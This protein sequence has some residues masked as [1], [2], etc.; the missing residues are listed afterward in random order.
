[1]A[2]NLAPL[3]R[4]SDGRWRSFER[5]FPPAGLDDEEI[6]HLLRYALLERFLGGA[7]VTGDGRA[8]LANGQ[9]IAPSLAAM[10]A[11]MPAAHGLGR[12]HPRLQ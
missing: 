5:N 12:A 6:S 9:Y 4:C 11:A 1:M 7:M 8:L 10:P 2:A 3:R